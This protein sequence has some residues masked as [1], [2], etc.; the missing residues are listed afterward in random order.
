MRLEVKGDKKALKS[1]LEKFA[2]ALNDTYEETKDVWEKRLRRIPTRFGKVELPEMVFTVLD[3]DEDDKLIFFHSMPTPLLHKVL[4]LPIRR[5]KKNL[6]GYVE[7]MGGKCE[8][9]FLGD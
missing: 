3:T 7:S 4:R 9:K 5:M 1:I 8:V 6:K 2:E